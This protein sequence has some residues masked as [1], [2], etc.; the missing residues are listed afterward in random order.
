M[1]SRDPGVRL[2]G[3]GPL[4]RF[5]SRLPSYGPLVLIVLF[6]LAVFGWLLLQ[7]LKPTSE[8]LSLKPWEFPS[9]WEW[10]N[11]TSAWQDAQISSYFVNSLFVSLGAP[12]ISLAVATPAAYALARFPRTRTS[13]VMRQSFF[14]GLLMAPVVLIVPLYFELSAVRMLDTLTGLV[15]IY[16]GL[17]LPFTVW[18]LTS[19]FTVLP[20]ELEEA[21]A[22]DGASVL[23]TFVHVFLPNV[24][25]GLF[26]V[27]LVNFL[28][29]WN[30]FFL[31]LTFLT[32]EEKST[33]ALGVFNLQ[34]N[35]TYGA[36]WPV[37]FAG[38]LIAIVPVL[39]LYTLLSQQITRA[40][41][42]G[43]VKG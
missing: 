27:F 7:A 30:E 8:F 2:T 42:Q 21:A 10:S 29:A 41:A 43:A 22:I 13:T 16:A 28:W 11:F 35:A 17:S 26:A 34:T 39:L 33:I 18:Y 20:H 19:F 40:M 38:M 31:A 15:V 14:V 25:S 3:R 1:T 6:N 12:L 4:A 9:T 24:L 32:S 5:G 37:L 36:N 23:S